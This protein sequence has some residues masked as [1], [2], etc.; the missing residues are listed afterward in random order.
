MIGRRKA[1][2]F[3][4]VRKMSKERMTF[5]ELPTAPIDSLFIALHE[6]L[7]Y[8]LTP[9]T[10]DDLALHTSQ[11]ARDYL[12]QRFCAALAKTENPETE[13]AIKELWESIK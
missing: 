6:V 13:K 5:R 2:H 1:A 3:F 8:K 7:A 11:A 9:P 12:A 10:C 4:G